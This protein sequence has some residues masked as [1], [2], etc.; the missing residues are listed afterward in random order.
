MKQSFDF[1]SCRTGADTVCD[2]FKLR[3][4]ISVELHFYRAGGS[5]RH[6]ELPQAKTNQNRRG[7]GVS[8]Q[9]A[10]DTQRLSGAGKG[11]ADLA[12]QAEQRR[13]IWLVAAADG[14]FE[15]AS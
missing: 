4:R 11:S 3:Q 8:A 9:L 13:V 5:L 7:Q 2:G 15:P 14:G 10:A 6:G 12:D 1:G